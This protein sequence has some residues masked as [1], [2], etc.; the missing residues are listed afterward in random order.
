[1]GTM[2]AL[3][4]TSVDAKLAWA[5]NHFQIV[6][7]EVIAWVNSK[8]HE[9]LFESNQEFSKF[10]L[11]VRL[12]GERPDFMRW[13]L[14][15]GDCVTN[16]RDTLDH[17]V[18]AIAHL[19]SSP[20][21]TKRGKAAFVIAPSLKDF[22]AWSDSRL[23][24]VPGGVKDAVLSF[25]PF[26]RQTVPH[27]PPLLKVLADLANGNKHRLL[28]VVLATPGLIDVEFVTT[29]GIIQ[30]PSFEI[31]KHDVRDGIP[32][33]IWEF[34]I[35]DP[36]LQLKRNSKIGLHVA[37]KHNAADGNTAFDADRTV[38]TALL[39]MLFTEVETVIETLKKLA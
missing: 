31:Y 17:L 35:P 37:I 7:N 28:G 33:C 21:P 29:S 20:N 9:I 34:P 25:Q 1:M 10:W 38:F 15:I 5:R 26:K 14:I 32:V 16:L 2:S 27:L 23:I 30:R 36:Q 6:Q 11:R 18:Y 12:K 8:P 39:D 3:D 22:N 24:S 13:S 4:T 19:P